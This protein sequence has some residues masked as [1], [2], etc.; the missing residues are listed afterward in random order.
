MLSV[1]H[2]Q[3]GPDYVNTIIIPQIES[4]LRKEIGHYN[5][6]EIYINKDNFLTEIIMK[7]LDEL[8]QKFVKINDVVIRAITFP[9]SIKKAIENKLV[10]EQQYQAY[11]FQLKIAE[12]EAKR[13]RIEAQGISNYQKII[14][15]TLNQK[16]AGAYWAIKKFKSEKE[17]PSK[18]E[19]L[20]IANNVDTTQPIVIGIAWP[21]EDSNFVKGAKLAAMEINN[22]KG[23]ILNRELKLIINDKEK[24]VNSLKLRRSQHVAVNVA[25]EF[26]SNPQVV[27]VIGHKYSKL[28]VPASIVYKNHG[29]V[30]I[31]PTS[32]N[33]K[34]TSNN[35]KYVFRLS[36]NNEEIGKQLA[37]YIHKTGY[38]KIII[39]HDRGSYA[40]ELV[41]SFI[42]NAVKTYDIEIILRRSFFSSKNDF[43]DILVELKRRKFDA[44]FVSTNASVAA[45]IYT[46]SRDMRI[47][48]PFIGGDALESE[49]FWNAVQEWEGFD[50]SEIFTK[51]SAVP[52]V[53][54]AN[55]LVKVTQSFIKKYQ[56]EYQGEEA[57]RMA[58][59]GYDAV[60][61]LEHAIKKAQSSLPIKIAETLRY[62]QPCQG[63]AGQY[64]FQI[65]GDIINKKL[66]FKFFK[67]QQ[68]EYESLN[69]S[70]KKLTSFKEE[71][72]NLDHD[73]D[74]I[75]NN[76][77]YC[78]DNNTTEIS[79]GV[80]Q[81]G[82]LRGCPIDSDRDK[83]AD[84]RDDCPNNLSNE[85]SKGVDSRGCPMDKDN[86]T[87][88]DYLDD[89]PNNLINEIS[90][91]IDLKGCP[92]DTDTD[93]IA[94]Y[95]DAC[96]KNSLIELSKGINKIGCPIDSDNDNVPDYRD[97]CPNNLTNEISKGV[98]LKGCPVDNDQD[99]VQDYKDQ[100]EETPRE[101]AIEL[102]GC[103]IIEKEKH[104]LLGKASFASG[105][106]KLSKHAQEFLKLLAQRVDL[107]LLIK[108]YIFGHTDS[109]GSISFNQKLSQKRA[110]NIGQYLI[111]QGIPSDKIEAIG[112]GESEPIASND[113]SDGRDKNRRIEI[114]VTYFKKKIN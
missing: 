33:L 78:P 99:G 20:K 58:A 14:S 76:L 8:G 114:R 87:V 48:A 2:Q 107:N 75:V 5:P 72:G 49:I 66:Y 11:H 57:N 84:Y 110:N 65:N 15:E 90:K 40:N 61:L 13:K 101:I 83:I 55:S 69:K 94:D 74:N 38:K 29:I 103:P 106:E 91:G 54:N 7:A 56:Q 24:V 81:K 113:T 36:P 23:K 73:K 17:E 62:M 28:A 30:F 43:T 112:M 6:E 102:N 86:D 63:T 64:Q 68:F 95:Q 98:D 85:I 10:K 37:A 34:L 32:T 45:Q 82:A 1:L 47:M 50:G 42:S 22:K 59:L 67:D 12:Q 108:I 71:C 109:I 100:C 111:L 96:P 31:S 97:N 18:K 4:I 51:K 21:D 77:D 92:V 89:C 26:A 19:G 60:K 93:S 25:N 41:N 79:K 9:D 35:F 44:I 104:I 39:L 27:A 88:L 53:F 52:T 80:Y 70:T 16:G 105:K 3:V 46:Q